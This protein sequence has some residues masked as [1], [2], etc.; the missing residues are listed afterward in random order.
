MIEV[1]TVKKGR[2]AVVVPHGVLFRGAAEGRIRQQLIEENLLDA[3]IGLPGNLFPTTSIPVAILVFDRSRE[4]GG[5][6]L[7][8]A[9]SQYLFRSASFRKAVSIL[10]QGSHA[11]IFLKIKV[12]LPPLS[13]QKQ[14][15]RILLP[16]SEKL[17]YSN[18]WQTATAL[19]NAA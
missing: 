8:P 9:F 18:N 6:K 10:A 3:V 4:T 5:K 2:V 14:I 16:P 15:A 7:L 19:K 13:E 12:L 11:S 17:T 1:A